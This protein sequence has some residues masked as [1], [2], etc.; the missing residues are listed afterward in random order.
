TFHSLRSSFLGKAEPK[1]QLLLP[2]W[3]RAFAKT[4]EIP[5]RGCNDTLLQLHQYPEQAQPRW[6][7][8]ESSSRSSSRPT[9]SKT[10]IASTAR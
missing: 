2:L 5:S 7:H 6:R 10:S 9:L 8:P 3:T 1:S 4:I